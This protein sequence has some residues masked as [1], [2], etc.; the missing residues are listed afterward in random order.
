MAMDAPP[1]LAATNQKLGQMGLVISK[2][3]VVKDY[4]L[5]Q[6]LFYYL[7]LFSKISV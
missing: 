7:E 1:V 6:L 3:A 2:K 5:L 4:N